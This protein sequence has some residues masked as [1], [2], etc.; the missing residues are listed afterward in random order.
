MKE[1]EERWKGEEGR[2]GEGRGGGREG[3]G[4]KKKKME[5]YVK[6][7]PLQNAKGKQ[8]EIITVGTIG[9]V[10]KGCQITAVDLFK[11]PEMRNLDVCIVLRKKKQ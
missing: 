11:V 7:F 5:K 10:H 3:E 8:G 9:L 4:G 1:Q 6:A 2:R